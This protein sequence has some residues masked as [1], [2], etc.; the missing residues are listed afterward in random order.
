MDQKNETK[1]ALDDQG[2]LAVSVETAAQATEKTLLA[3]FGV[4]RDVKGEVSQRALGVID[5]VDATQQGLVKLARSLVQR[6]DEVAT[7]WIDANEQL[8]LGVV[9]ALRSTG[10]G[11]THL[12]SRTAASLTSTRREIVAQA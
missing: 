11:A 9:H 3:Y 7:A 5:W 10:H 2:I 6:T 1:R 12:A 4:V 8:A